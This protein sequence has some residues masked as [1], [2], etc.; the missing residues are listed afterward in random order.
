MIRVLRAAQ[1]KRNMQTMIFFRYRNAEGWGF[2]KKLLNRCHVFV[3]RINGVVWI[4]TTGTMVVF[5][6]VLLR[7]AD[8]VLVVAEVVAMAVSGEVD[9]GRVNDGTIQD[10]PT[11]L[12]LHTEKRASPEHRCHRNLI[13]TPLDTTVPFSRSFGISK[14][15]TLSLSSKSQLLSHTSTLVNTES[16]SKHPS[17]ISWFHSGVEVEEMYGVS[18]IT[19]PF[20]PPIPSTLTIAYGSTDRNWGRTAPTTVIY[21][22][23]CFAW[24]SWESVV[25]R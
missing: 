15:A 23:P 10:T 25:I 12:G 4:L 18:P 22:V 6:P 21:S 11:F 17:S 19:I 20:A 14:K 13:V 9:V 24:S 8:M 16:A 5:A 7:C 3:V 2:E 1:V